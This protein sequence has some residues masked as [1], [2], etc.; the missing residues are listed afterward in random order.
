MERGAS[1]GSSSRHWAPLV[2]EVDLFP[3]LPLRYPPF[4]RFSSFR[5]SRKSWVRHSNTGKI[6]RPFSTTN[7]AASMQTRRNWVTLSP[8][9]S[10]RLKQEYL[11]GHREF[12][13]TYKNRARKTWWICCKLHPHWGHRSDGHKNSSL[14]PLRRYGSAPQWLVKRF[15]PSLNN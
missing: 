2:M 15:L 13:G 14:N 3:E 4:F 5:N 9:I 11:V 1:G 10:R 12:F 7:A 6:K 8:L